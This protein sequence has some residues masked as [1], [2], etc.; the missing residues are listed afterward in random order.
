MKRM[1]GTTFPVLVASALTL[2]AA[3]PLAAQTALG[4][5]EQRNALVDHILQLTAAREAWSPVKEANMEYSPL[6]DMEAVRSDVVGARTEEELF[7]ALVKLSNMR[8]DSHLS[9][10]AV[11]G[12]LRLPDRPVLRAAVNVLADFSD[13]VA[14][15]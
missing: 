2:L 3:P 13:M 4:T 9:V 6:V 8:R 12:G 5:V 7:F 15:S 1:Q 14:P 11:D 10:S